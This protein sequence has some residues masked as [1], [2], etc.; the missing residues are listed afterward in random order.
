MSFTYAPDPTPPFAQDAFVT[1]PSPLARLL[2][3]NPAPYP[4]PCL[5]STF[6]YS[7]RASANV[8]Y[9]VHA[10]MYMNTDTHIITPLRDN[11]TRRRLPRLNLGLCPPLLPLCL[12]VTLLAG[13]GYSPHNVM[14]AVMTESSQKAAGC[15][16]GS[17]C[18]GR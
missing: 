2:S 18:C 5:L 13:G 9:H 10:N 14:Q 15:N 3:Y 1:R 17:S 6:H 12:L 11:N 4:L 7:E 16:R 8:I